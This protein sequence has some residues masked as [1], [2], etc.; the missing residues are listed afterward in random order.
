MK[1]HQDYLQNEYFQILTHKTEP[2]VL[3]TMP[4]NLTLAD[5]TL[6]SPVGSL[7]TIINQLRHREPASLLGL[8]PYPT[9]YIGR[10]GKQTHFTQAAIKNH[11]WIP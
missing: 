6:P 3:N 5:Y 9:T 10:Q 8:L 4:S 2:N 11:P 1:L 7:S